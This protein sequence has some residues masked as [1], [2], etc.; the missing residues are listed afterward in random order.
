MKNVNKRGALQMKAC[1]YKNGAVFRENGVRG[2]SVYEWVKVSWIIASQNLRSPQVLGVI[3]FTLALIIGIWLVTGYQIRVEHQHVFEPA[4]IAVLMVG[5]AGVLTAVLILAA[6]VLIVTMG[7]LIVGEEAMRRLASEMKHLAETDSLTGLPNR[8]YLTAWLNDRERDFAR[9]CLSLLFIDLND[10][11]RINDAMGHRCGDDLLK[12]VARRLSDISGAERTV[13]RVGGDEFVIPVMG[14][15]S[16]TVA[17]NLAE[18]IVDGFEVAFGIRGDSCLIKLS[19]GI[20]TFDN[21]RYSTYD[22]LWQADLAMYA[23]KSEGKR[24]GESRIREFGVELSELVIE[25]IKRQQELQSAIRNEEFFIEYQPIVDPLTEMPCGAEALVRW[26][27]PKHGILPSINFMPF[28]EEKGFAIQIGELAIRMLISEWGELGQKGGARGYVCF[29]VSAT[30][31]IHGEL[32]ELLRDLLKRS[33]VDASNICIMV[34]EIEAHE[35]REVI[36]KRIDGLRS[37]GIKII[38]DLFGSG[39]SSVNDIRNFSIDGIRLDRAIISS[40]DD[41]QI[42]LAVFQGVMA[43]GQKIGLPIIVNGVDSSI[44]IERLKMYPGIAAQ[45][46]M[47]PP[48]LHSDVIQ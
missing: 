15:H 29:C 34:K 35:E 13:F 4:D 36:K 10:F 38:L 9:G 8:N 39:R 17:N 48:A 33:K 37:I 40:I 27:H 22:L 30:Q 7:R 14:D 3:F 41:D 5:F 23:A 26:Q 20:S 42:E 46:A 28:A 21:E 12:G 11:K 1:A 6:M 45:G 43:L 32:I 25:D 2:K 24:I 16:A 18:K 19:I 31:L 44:Q 47:W